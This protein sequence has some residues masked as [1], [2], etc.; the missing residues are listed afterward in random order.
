MK[1]RPIISVSI[2]LVVFGVI[3][4]SLLSTNQK[5]SSAAWRKLPVPVDTDVLNVV[6][7]VNNEFSDSWKA[8]DLEAAAPASV[9]AVM[10]RAS[11]ALHG[12]VPSLE[13]IREFGPS[14]QQGKTIAVEYELMDRYIQYLLADRRYADY[15]SERFARVFVGVDAGPFLVYRR[16]RFQLWLS[17][18]LF[19]NRPYD[20]L[21]RELISGTGVWVSDPA[22]NFVTA[23]ITDDSGG[24]PDLPKLAGRTSRAFLGMRL[25]CLQCHDDALGTIGLSFD[26][27]SREALQTDFHQFAAFYSQASISLGGVQDDFH[28]Y[29]YTYLGDEKD[30]HIAP[31]V[32]FRSDL[33]L[34]TGSRRGQL[35]NWITARQN[36]AFSRTAV[37][38]VWAIIFGKPLVDPVDDI[39]LMGPFPPG[40]E[41]LATDFSDHDYDLKRLIQIITRLDVFRISSRAAFEVTL[42]HERAW[43]VF[44]LV[45]LRP[46][47]VAGGIGQTAKVQTI[48]ADVSYTV[49]QQQQQDILSFVKRYGDT[50]EDEFEDRGGT[51]TQR[52]L[53]MNGN[54]VTDRTRSSDDSNTA[55]RIAA[56]AEDDT[57]AIEITYLCVLTRL[58]SETE[59]NHFLTALHAVSPGQREQVLE[60]L[61][62]TLI[63]S[64]EFSWNH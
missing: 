63:N 19:A 21:C 55:A 9:R 47:Q 42:Q 39:P 6:A 59:R 32:P 30:S 50:G 61:F 33:E 43:T 29:F 20:S 8:A 31:K 4:S 7:A 5:D 22:V 23:T 10:R 25:D 12:T 34:P 15:V 44:P 14:D 57:D 16:R 24:R 28:N 51:I 13:E 48:N 62:W 26:G 35:A 17:D 45:R 3:S 38:R 49:R 18:Q 41:L 46:E 2:C 37:N 11:L 64:T 56:I 52:L 36:K 60:D 54:F 53:M 40:L 58:P 27:I 1:W